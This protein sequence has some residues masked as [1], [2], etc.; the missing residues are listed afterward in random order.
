[1]KE[2]K[3]S[4]GEFF[5]FFLATPKKLGAT[6]RM[7]E[8]KVEGTKFAFANFPFIR[9]GVFSFAYLR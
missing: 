5:V 2:E 4:R 8:E 9:A 6:A 7:E 3:V 1:M